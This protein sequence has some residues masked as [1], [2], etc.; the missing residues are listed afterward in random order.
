MD[1]LVSHQPIPKSLPSPPNMRSMQVK[2]I[3]QLKQI[4]EVKQTFLASRS[5]YGGN[6]FD[7]KR[8]TATRG[9]KKNL[10]YP[11]MKI[12]LI[13]FASITPT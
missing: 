12:G 5:I 8:S 9:F 4:G 10:G 3:R 2:Q 6:N 11:M 13:Q 7:E 1:D